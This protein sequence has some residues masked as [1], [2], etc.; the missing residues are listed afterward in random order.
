MDTGDNKSDYKGDYNDI[1]VTVI[2]LGYELNNCIGMDDD[3][4]RQYYVKVTDRELSM[5][6]QSV[7]HMYDE[8]GTYFHVLLKKLSKLK[9]HTDFKVEPTY[10]RSYVIVVH[11]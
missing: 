1:K 11:R 4:V 3:L 10:Q 5:L 2:D 8:S 6:K 7:Y 9:P